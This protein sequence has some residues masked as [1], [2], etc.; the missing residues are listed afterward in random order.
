MKNKLAH[1]LGLKILALG[2][3][4][5]LW[6]VVNN[7]TDPVGEKSFYNVPVEIVNEDMI[8]EEGKVYEV[9]EGTDVINV[10][11]TGKKS[12]ISYINKEDI[13]AVADLS[14]LTFMNTVSI[15]VSKIIQN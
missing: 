15:K 13:K 11:V 8:A 7:I 9:L 2:F 5:G 4:V 3:S 14:E 12:V 1:N 6:F 10:K